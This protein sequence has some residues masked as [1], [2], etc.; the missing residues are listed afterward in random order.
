MGLAAA[1]LAA[2]RLRY[3]LMTRNPGT[4]LKARSL[5]QQT[6]L[7]N[8]GRRLQN[9]GASWLLAACFLGTDVSFFTAKRENL[10]GWKV[11]LRRN[12]TTRRASRTCRSLCARLSTFCCACRLFRVSSYDILACE[13]HAPFV[14]VGGACRGRFRAQVRFMNSTLLCS[15]S[16][17]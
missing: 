13:H 3:C 12:S 9:S 15:S 6:L 4:H 14:F 2:Q 7:S 11:L 1:F 16:S 5:S 8:A 10:V 17:L